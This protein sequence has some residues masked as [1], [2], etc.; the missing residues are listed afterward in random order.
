MFHTLSR[1]LKSQVKKYSK[2][3]TGKIAIVTGSGR[4]MGAL[5]AEMLANQGKQNFF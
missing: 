2:E 4:G 1:Q 5:T 3:F